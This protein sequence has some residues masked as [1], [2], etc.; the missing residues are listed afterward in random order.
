MHFCKRHNASRDPI[1]LKRGS[2]FVTLVKKVIIR[3]DI[4]Y[5]IVLSDI[6]GSV[7][8]ID[9]HVSILGNAQSN[10]EMWWHNERAPQQQLVMSGCSLLRHILTI[11]SKSVRSFMNFIR[12]SV[13]IHL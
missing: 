5:S 10:T 2:D 4:M 13:G 1:I 11:S 12:S 9:L 3:W 6:Y 8:M 7:D